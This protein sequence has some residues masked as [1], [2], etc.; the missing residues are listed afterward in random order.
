MIHHLT[1]RLLG[2]CFCIAVGREDE[3]WRGELARW[4]DTPEFDEG[5]V[6]RDGC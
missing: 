4:C 2:W 3:L 1:F 6:F 5:D